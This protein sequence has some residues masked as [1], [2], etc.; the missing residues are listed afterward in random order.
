[1]RNEEEPVF[2]YVYHPGRA[3]ESSGNEQMRKR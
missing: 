2:P 1:M 3:L